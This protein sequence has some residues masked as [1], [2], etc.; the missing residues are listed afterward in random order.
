[1]H[2]RHAQEPEIKEEIKEM[3]DSQKRKFPE[4][5]EDINVIVV[6]MR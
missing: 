1:M 3:V 5:I 6:R 2:Q 4:I